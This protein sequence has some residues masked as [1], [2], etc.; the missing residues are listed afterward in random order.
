LPTAQRNG[1][2]ILSSGLGIADNEALSPSILRTSNFLDR[3]C[4]AGRSL[5]TS[6]RTPEL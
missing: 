5:C 2:L 1:P 3:T 6:W 4:V